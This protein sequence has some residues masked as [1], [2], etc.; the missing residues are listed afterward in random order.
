M[1]NVVLELFRNKKIDFSDF[2]FSQDP[3]KFPRCGT[4]TEEPTAAPPGL[5]TEETIHKVMGASLQG[6]WAS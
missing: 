5:H 2:S 3:N 1:C 4:V 6:H